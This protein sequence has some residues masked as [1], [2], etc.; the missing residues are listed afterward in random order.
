MSSARL[1]LQ[2]LEEVGYEDA[3]AAATPFA[4]KQ[5]AAERIAAHRARRQ[6]LAPAP[7][8]PAAIP[9][10]H[11]ARAAQI[12][13]AVAERYAHS[14]SYRAFLAAEAQKAIDQAQ[15]AAHVAVRTAQA[16]AEAQYS[17]IAE[18]DQLVLTPPEPAPAP[19]HSQPRP[20]LNSP[21]AAAPRL[22]QP[23]QPASQPRGP[24]TVRLLEDLSTPGDHLAEAHTN[25]LF[26]PSPDP[27]GDEGL[28][29]DEEIAFR[30]SPVFEPAT[31]PTEIP[32]NLIE[33]PRHLIAARR[34]RPRIAEGPL[35]EDGHEEHDA[36]QLRIFEV[37]A[38]QISTAPAAESAVTEWSSIV[39]GAHPAT[40]I[41]DAYYTPEYAYHYAQET[42]SPA[43]NPELPPATAP[44]NLRLM[45]AAV[46]SCIILAAI[47]AFTAVAAITIGN[48]PSGHLNLQTAAIA[49]AGTLVILTAL[50]QLLFFTLSDGTPGMRYARIALCT[51][52][53]ENPSRSAMRRRV[54]ALFLSVCPLGIGILWAWLDPDRLGWHDR[55]SRMYQRSY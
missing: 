54:L 29:L 11:N 40:T 15:A 30:Q 39:L 47:V 36:A 5:Q 2:Q 55:I 26:S 27:L 33:F 7:A 43:F 45:A 22:V 37:E 4:L 25:S 38:T 18:L 3:P 42:A 16:V 51:F 23:Q 24:I 46:D 8:A 31:P 34:A 6:G 53:D 21:S 9:T 28:A 13:A 1:D 48:L 17:L 19:I 20:P 44:F 49:E 32:A 12:A 52:D 10:P 41:N 14:Q 35:R 50:Y